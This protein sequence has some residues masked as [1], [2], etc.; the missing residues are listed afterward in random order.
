MK[1]MAE[2]DGANRNLDKACVQ[3]WLGS[4]QRSLDR[5]RHVRRWRVRRRADLAELGGVADELTEVDRR[6][7]ELNR[8]AAAL[9][10]EHLDTALC[11]SRIRW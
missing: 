5:R 7:D 1:V 4:A 11:W 6:A 10:D 8:R 3:P 2:A 9:L